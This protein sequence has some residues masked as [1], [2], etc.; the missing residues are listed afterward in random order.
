MLS[1]RSSTPPVY[2]RS[3]MRAPLPCSALPLPSESPSCALRILP[4]LPHFRALVAAVALL[5]CRSLPL[6]CVG[7]EVAAELLDMRAMHTRQPSAYL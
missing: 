5:R 3:P 7:C 4:A 6:C 2:L 1:A